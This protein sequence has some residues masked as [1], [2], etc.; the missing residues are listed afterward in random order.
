MYA[1]HPR[2]LLF[3][4][5]F[6]GQLLWY[7]V[8]CFGQIWILSSSPWALPA[9]QGGLLKLPTT[10]N[11]CFW[12]SSPIQR[13]P[14]VILHSSKPPSIKVEMVCAHPQSGPFEA[15][16]FVRFQF[17]RIRIWVCPAPIHARCRISINSTTYIDKT[18]QNILLEY[19]NKLHHIHNT[20]Q[21]ILLEYLIKSTAYI[22]KTLQNTSLEYLINSTTYT[23]LILP[24][25]QCLINKQIYTHLLYDCL[26]KESFSS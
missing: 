13:L 14:P 18:L 12:L 16:F 22:G 7:C 9:S 21:N 4:Q 8:G 6:F 15:G 10:P 11:I 17:E 23:T 26:L 25:T 24:S 1:F 2:S 3:N 5:T 20:F 19:P